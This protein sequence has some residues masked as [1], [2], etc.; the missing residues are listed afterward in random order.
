MSL[1]L[2]VAAPFRFTRKQRLKR[3]EV[4]YFLVYD[5]RWMSLDEANQ[6]LSR[7]LEDGLLAYDGEMLHPLFDLSTVNI[8]IGFKPTT[9]I[10]EP[11]EPIETLIERIAREKNIPPAQLTGEMNQ[12]ILDGFEGHIR[13]E[14]AIV[15]LAK[16]YRI[17]TGDLLQALEASLLKN[18]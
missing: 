2:T 14:A 12:L 6:L 1:M 7:A 17:E 15:I 5:R 10:L 18:R 8:P 13:P 11:K 9:V 4:V 3:N 16:K